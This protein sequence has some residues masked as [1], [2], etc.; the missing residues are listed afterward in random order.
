MWTIG[1]WGIGVSWII[2]SVYYY[3][4]IGY[5]A[6]S[7]VYMLFLI[8]ILLFAVAPIRLF[9]IKKETDTQKRTRKEQKWKTNRWKKT[10]NSEICTKVWILGG[11]ETI[12]IYV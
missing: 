2:V 3:G 11:G 9:K 10:K 12:Y 7:I 1:H 6:S 4:N 5:I 8:L